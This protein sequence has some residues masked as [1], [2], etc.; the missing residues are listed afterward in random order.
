MGT[1]VDDFE[2]VCRV[3]FENS[4]ADLLV[5]IK[6]QLKQTLFYLGVFGG[7]FLDGGESSDGLVCGHEILVVVAGPK[8][9]NTSANQ[10]F[11]KKLRED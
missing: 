7:G 8:L 9:A 3:P 6:L 11:V 10:N 5:L 2:C 4:F 1:F